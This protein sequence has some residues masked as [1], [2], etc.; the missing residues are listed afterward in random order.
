LFELNNFFNFCPLTMFDSSK[1][2]HA[3]PLQY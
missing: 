2:A 3:L 1:C